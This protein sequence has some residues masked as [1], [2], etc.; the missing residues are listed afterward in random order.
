M[1][2]PPGL[3]LTEYQEFRRGEAAA[4]REQRVDPLGIGVEQISRLGRE[5]LKI[6]ARPLRQAERARHA[7]QAERL[8]P[9]DFRQPALGAAAHHVHLEH[10]VP[11]VQPAERDGRIAFRPCRDARD[12]VV[13]EG[14]G[15]GSR[16]ARDRQFLARIGQ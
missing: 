7:V 16:K 3:R 11:R 5:A 6:L 10:A 2:G 4:H 8:R 14:D 15:N 12:A 13:V 9:R 1:L